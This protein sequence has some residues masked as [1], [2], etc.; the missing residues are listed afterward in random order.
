ME[1]GRRNRP[2]ALLLS[3]SGACCSVGPLLDAVDAAV[4]SLLDALDPLVGTV[5]LSRRAVVE[6][7]LLVLE[8][9]DL[10][11]AAVVLA[12][13]LAIL[14]VLEALELAIIAVVLARILAIVAVLLADFAALLAVLDG[15]LQNALSRGRGGDAG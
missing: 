1:P 10:A 4:G 6:P 8:A 3:L 7:L 13:L 11:L 9:V 12:R 2:G 5:G 14:L 15:V